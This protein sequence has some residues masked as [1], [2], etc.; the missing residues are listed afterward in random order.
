MRFT[1]SRFGSPHGAR[2]EAVR[3]EQPDD[4]IGEQREVSVVGVDLAA[5][6]AP[7]DRPSGQRRRRVLGENFAKRS[8]TW[9]HPLKS[10]SMA[11]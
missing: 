1:M 7:P 2:G 9:P 8:L 6:T 4:A 5:A 11:R 10:T 3:L